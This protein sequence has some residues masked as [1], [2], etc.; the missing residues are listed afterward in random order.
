[1]VWKLVIGE[2]FVGPSS[3]V[4]QISDNSTQLH[5]KLITNCITKKKKT[6]LLNCPAA[7]FVNYE[8]S[9]DI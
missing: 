6:I 1:M 9:T 7:V 3:G 2:S 5:N 8:L 4:E